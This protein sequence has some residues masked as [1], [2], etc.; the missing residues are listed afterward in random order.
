VGKRR[1]K[2]KPPESRFIL[3]RFNGD[4]VYRFETAVMW[5]YVKERG[6]GVT[7]WFEVS[8]DPDALRRC[9]DT[10]ELGMSPNAEVGIDLPELDA[11]QLVGRDFVIPGT[12]SDD[13]DSCM[14]LLY[15]CEH[16]PLRDNHI[17]VVSR[18]RDRFWLRWTAAVQDVNYYDGSKPPAR[19]EIEGEFV[20]QDIAKWVR[21]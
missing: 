18:D 5:A 19:V 6:P 8:A 7:L 21:A 4:E 14:S 1:T 13:E 2:A 9:E 11:G 10:A 15:Y 12:Q 16:E 3:H 20:F 17:R